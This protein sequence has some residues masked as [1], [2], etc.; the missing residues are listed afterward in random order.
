MYNFTKDDYF[1]AIDDIPYVGYKAEAEAFVDIPDFYSIYQNRY[2]IEKLS[3]TFKDYL[4]DEN[5]Y[6]LNELFEPYKKEPI[7]VNSY[8]FS[9]NE[10][11][12][13]QIALEE[14]GN[15][16]DW[17]ILLKVPSVGDF[18]WGDA[19]DLFFVIHKSD[20][21]KQDFSNVICTMYSS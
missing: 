1:E 11:P 18:Q 19:G 9:Q 3:Q 7:A 10:Y 16:Q 6:V 15:P 4:T 2:L 13:H 5:D 8:G 20:L 14:K 17:M 21:A 12:E